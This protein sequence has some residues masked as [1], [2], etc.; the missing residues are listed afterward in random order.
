MNRL[1]ISLFSVMFMLSG[2]VS[3]VNPTNEVRISEGGVSKL[4]GSIASCRVVQE[5]SMPNIEII[6]NGEKCKV[7]KLSTETITEAK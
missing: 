2:C 3:F 7:R 1:L 5:G 6:Y 4:T